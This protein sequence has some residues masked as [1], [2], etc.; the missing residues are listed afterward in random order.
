MK[1]QATWQKK[2]KRKKKK[3]DR[4]MIKCNSSHFKRFNQEQDPCVLPSAR[5]LTA[6]PAGS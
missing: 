4:Q 2:R 3:T 6:R 1:E 5:A